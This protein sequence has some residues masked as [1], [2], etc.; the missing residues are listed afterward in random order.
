MAEMLTLTRLFVSIQFFI[1]VCLFF[2]SASLSGRTGHRVRQRRMRHRLR[3]LLCSRTRYNYRTH[4]R[5]RILVQVVSLSLFDA[6]VLF[7]GARCSDESGANL[8]RYDFLLVFYSYLN[9]GETV[10]EL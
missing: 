9:L 2:T 6:S 4:S 1:F 8:A 10:I 5:C 7:I 3:H